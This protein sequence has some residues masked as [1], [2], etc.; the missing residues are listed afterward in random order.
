MDH[1]VHTLNPAHI[2]AVTERACS[3]PYFKLISMRIPELA[4]GTSLV[5]VSVEKKHLQPWGRVHGGVYAAMVDVAAFWAVYTKIP[6]GMGM[7]TVEIKLNYLAPAAGGLLRASGTAVKVGKTL[8]LGTASVETGD[9]RLLAHGT[10]TFMILD[11]LS[12]EAPTPLPPK[13][14]D[15]P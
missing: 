13:F 15:E 5:E 11:D 9:G 2:G 12:L 6:D 4:W 14:L 8:A 1:R 10:A 3:S 7:T